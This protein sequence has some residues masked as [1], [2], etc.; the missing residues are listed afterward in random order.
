LLALTPLSSSTTRVS[1]SLLTRSTLSSTLLA[2]PYEFASSRIRVREARGVFCLHQQ[3]PCSQVKPFWPALFE[4]VLAGKNIDDLLLNVGAGT[5]APAAA[6]PAAAPAAG[7]EGAGKEGAGKE[8]AGKGG[9][10]K[11]P[12]KEEKKP[13]EPEPEEEDMGLSL[14]D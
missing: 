6:A 5:G 12:P 4:K 8:G 1:L 2:C 9:K 11:E 13:P 3:L 10:S 14:F 7:K